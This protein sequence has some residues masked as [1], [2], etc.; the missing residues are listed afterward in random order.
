MKF[1]VTF[2]CMWFI[3]RQLYLRL[4]RGIGKS[5]LETWVL[6]VLLWS[7][8]RNKGFRSENLADGSYSSR[9]QRLL[10]S[11]VGYRQ[12]FLRIKQPQYTYGLS[13]AVRVS[14]GNM[15]GGPTGSS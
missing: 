14:R 3:L 15:P 9:L 4:V 2:L 5:L 10:E 7:S 8:L 12:S 11:K 13:T 1:E 6:L